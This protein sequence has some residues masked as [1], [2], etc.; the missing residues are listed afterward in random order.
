MAFPYLTVQR[1]KYRFLLLNGSQARVYNL[2]LYLPDPNDRT[3]IRMVTDPGTGRLIPDITKA[4]PPIIQV[5]TEGGFLPDAV[6]FNNPPVPFSA[7]YDLDGSYIPG[8][9]VHGLLLR[10]PSGRTW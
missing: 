5:G 8:T 4:G 9:M 2:G 1:R 7:Q 3:N 10:A 6:V